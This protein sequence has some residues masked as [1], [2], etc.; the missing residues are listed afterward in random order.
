MNNDKHQL[1]EVFKSWFTEEE[2]QILE[3]TYN[4]MYKELTEKENK[5]NSDDEPMFGNH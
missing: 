5:T 2:L 1:S 4:K 3:D